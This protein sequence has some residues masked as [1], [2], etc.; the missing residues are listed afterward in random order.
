MPSEVIAWKKLLP[1]GIRQ[2]ARAGVTRQTLTAQW[3]VRRIHARLHGN[4]LHRQPACMPQY[5]RAVFR[6]RRCWFPS[7]RNASVEQ[8]ICSRLMIP[9]GDRHHGT[10]SRG[11]VHEPYAA[12]MTNDDIVGVFVLNDDILDHLHGREVQAPANDVFQR[13]LRC[14]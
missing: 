11:I 5:L 3:R 4:D 12:G 8:F 14:K 2:N 7:P 9:D 10:E 6:A 1:L 13:F